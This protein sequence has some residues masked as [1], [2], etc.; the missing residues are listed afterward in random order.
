MLSAV[1]L[2]S[3]S[4]P[5]DPFTYLT[6]L[7]FPGVIIGLFLSGQ[8]RTKGEL[9]NAISELRRKDEI[10]AAKD[11]QIE[12]MQAGI[13]DKAIPALTEAT[14]LMDELRRSAPDPRPF[15]RRDRP[16]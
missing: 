9:E 16:G 1:V 10:I 6:G 7:G 12:S 15:P 11:K 3:G 5:S 4:V 13:V 8:L 2:A 14:N